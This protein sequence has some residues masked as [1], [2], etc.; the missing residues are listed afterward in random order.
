QVLG[1]FWQEGNKLIQRGYLTIPFP[2]KEIEP[3]E[4]QI[5]AKFTLQD[6]LGHLLS[7][8]ATQRYIKKHKTDPLLAL[9]KELEKHWKNPMEVKIV[10]WDIMLRVGKTPSMS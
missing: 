8:S 9:E 7:W 10:R 3:P 5:K 4:F 2:F 1:E 6:L